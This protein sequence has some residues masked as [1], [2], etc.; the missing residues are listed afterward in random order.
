MGITE[1][2]ARMTEEHLN[3]EAGV[4]WHPEQGGGW[5]AGLAGPFETA[6]EA[7]TFAALAH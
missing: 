7:R 5:W 2:M 1:R 6:E 4:S 3:R